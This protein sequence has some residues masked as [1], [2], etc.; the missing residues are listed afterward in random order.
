MTKRD[1]LVALWQLMVD[2]F[3][4]KGTA[5]RLAE[6]SGIA[7]QLIDS[8]GTAADYWWRVLVSA[9]QRDKMQDLVKNTAW[10]VAERDADLKRAYRDYDEAV[11]DGQPLDRPS[12]PTSAH[13]SV[14]NTG[15]GA[16]VG[17]NVNAGGDFVGRDKIVQSDAVRGDK[18]SVG[19]ISGQ[20]NASIGRG[21]SAS[22]QQ[23]IDAAQLETIL[24]PVVAAI[25]ASPQQDQRP[26]MQSVEKLETELAK[27]SSA[28]DRTVAR[29]IDGL[30]D[31]AP[32]AVAALVSA[33]ASPLL[34]PLAGPATQYVLDKIKGT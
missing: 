6:Q 24:A 15:G 31:I 30:V 26:A 1:A 27:G 8:E 7:P 25:H 22:Q 12:A 13:N 5:T 17:G 34:A 11:D 9:H 29:L 14:V 32:G 18:I 33:F 3:P 21:A 28:D 16:Y 2:L 19:S 23:G 10:E 20:A 4:D